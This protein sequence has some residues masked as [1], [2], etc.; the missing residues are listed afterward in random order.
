MDFDDDYVRPSKSAQ[1][2]EAQAI[3]DLGK[4]LVDYPKSVLSKLSLDDEL[5]AAIKA[6]QDF[7]AHGARRRQLQLVAKL[8]RAADL[9][10][11]QS[12]IQRLEMG[13]P[14]STEAHP[15]KPDP[16]QPWLEK[17]AQNGDAAINEMLEEGLAVDRQQL[18]QLLRNFNK[19]PQPESKAHK[20]L[21]QYL[22]D[23][24]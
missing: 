4:K 5:R 16:I 11:L 14:I 13:L 24:L 22:R 19:S 23:I 7:N 15:G 6:A 1:K 12:E 18:R 10:T 8:L 2:R 9:E 17:L 21:S 20:A 3:H